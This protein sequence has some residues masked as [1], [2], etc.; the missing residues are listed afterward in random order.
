ML[1]Q[2]GTQLIP[3]ISVLGVSSTVVTGELTAQVCSPRCQ[4]M[5]PAPAVTVT[6]EL[7]CGQRH[8]DVIQTRCKA[9]ALVQCSCHTPPFE[10]H[11]H[12]TQSCWEAAS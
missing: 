8:H 7:I 12:V 9:A 3:S 5:M 1:T 2:I 10:G 11:L 6:A 4:I